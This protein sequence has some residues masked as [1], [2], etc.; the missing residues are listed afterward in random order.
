[1]LKDESPSEADFLETVIIQKW[2]VPRTMLWREIA[3]F[4]ADEY[5]V[6]FD[7]VAKHLAVGVAT[8]RV[9]ILRVLHTLLMGMINHVW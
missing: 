6:S 2:L 3:G 5:F 9:A 1:M 8:E 7:R 4:Q